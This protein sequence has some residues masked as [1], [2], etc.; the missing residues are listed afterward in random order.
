MTEKPNFAAP[1][2]FARNTLRPFKAECVRQVAV[3]VRQLN[4]AHT[5]GISSALPGR[6]QRQGFEQAVP[7]S[8]ERAKNK[9]LCA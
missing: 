4:A 1:P 8:A 7:S 9:Q 3:E 6:W 2:P 5:Q